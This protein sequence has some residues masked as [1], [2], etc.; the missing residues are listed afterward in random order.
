MNNSF[1]N[2][3]VT[4]K[5]IKERLILGTIIFILSAAGIIFISEIFVIS[6]IIGLGF[7]FASTLSFKRGE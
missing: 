7:I 5:E 6:G 3:P 4:N 2:K 1:W